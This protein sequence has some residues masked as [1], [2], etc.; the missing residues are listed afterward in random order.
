M[1]EMR[2]GKDDC[3]ELLMDIFPFKAYMKHLYIPMVGGHIE[4]LCCVE[5]RDSLHALAARA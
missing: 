1:L 4:T 5:R 3:D 2:I